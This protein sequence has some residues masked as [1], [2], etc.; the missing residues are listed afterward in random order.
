MSRLLLC[1]ALVL[2]GAGRGRAALEPSVL[3]DGTL[4][5]LENVSS[6]VELTTRGEIG[7]VAM[8]FRDGNAA[9]VY[10]AT[11][12]KVRRLRMDEYC[13]ELAR[14]NKRRDD[15]ERI[16]ALA[17]RPKR[18]YAPGECEKMRA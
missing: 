6:V 18:D 10:E 16:R 9:W 7:H 14:L 3:P 2:G 5:F 13:A 4:I 12:G 11:P 17:L 15:D 8:V 1:L